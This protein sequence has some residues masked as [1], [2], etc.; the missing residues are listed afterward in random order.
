MPTRSENESVNHRTSRLVVS[1]AGRSYASSVN[2]WRLTRG[3]KRSR[4][5]DLYQTA[6]PSVTDAS[7]ASRVPVVLLNTSHYAAIACDRD[8]EELVVSTTLGGNHDRDDDNNFANSQP[9]TT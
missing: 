4:E 2:I 3:Q 1:E 5:S 7:V 6:E 8:S 9:N